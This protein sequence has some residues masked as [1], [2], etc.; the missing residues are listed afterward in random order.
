MEFLGEIA[1]ITTAICWAFT[2][3]FFTQAGRI[4]G[5]FNVNKIRLIM[6]VTIYCVALL[7]TTGRILPANLTSQQYFWL[8]LSGVVGLVIGDGAGFKAMVMI[9]P[10]LMM[11]IYSSAPIF[12]TILG[13]LWLGEKL[14]PYDLLGIALTIF[15]ISWVVLERKNRSSNYVQQGHP[16]SGN[17]ARGVIL[18]IIAGMGQGTGL[19]I[20]KYGMLSA[21]ESVPAMPAAFIRMLAAMAV[22]WLISGLRGRIPDTI[23]AVKNAK[24]MAFSFGGAMFGPFMGVWMSL[25]AVQYIEAGI[26][27]TLN[28]TTPIWIIPFVIFFYKEKVSLRAWLGAVITVGG[29]TLLMLN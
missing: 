29:I 14:G 19:V 5:S 8:G 18:G 24:A 15:G 28:S 23:K 20:A 25:V 2:S 1:A 17:L 16:D 3:I 26:A 6:A 4:I 9:G 11:L 21:G 22:I 13:W 7:I 10:R 12:A 27:A